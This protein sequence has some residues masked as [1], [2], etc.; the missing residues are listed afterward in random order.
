MMY[1]AALC[2]FLTVACGYDYRDKRIPNHLLIWMAVPEPGSAGSIV[3]SGTSGADCG[4][5]ISVLQNRV[6]GGGGREAQWG[7]GGLSARRQDSGFLDVFFADRSGDF[8]GE[9]V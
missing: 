3:L 2:V 7:H 9:N 4:I 8:I 1:L 5:S 6:P